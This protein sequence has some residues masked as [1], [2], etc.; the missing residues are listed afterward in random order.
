MQHA[1]AKNCSISAQLLFSYIW[2]SV[3]RKFLLRRPT[4]V[5]ILLMQ[6]IAQTVVHR[7][8]NWQSL[9]RLIHGCI[10]VVHELASVRTS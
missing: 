9:V 8:I 5:L 7:R 10:L 4:L 2:M 6:E 1:G 3:D